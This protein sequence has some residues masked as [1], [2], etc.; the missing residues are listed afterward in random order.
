MR[1]RHG[2]WSYR[3]RRFQSLRAALESVWGVRT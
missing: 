3:G 1:Y 2:V